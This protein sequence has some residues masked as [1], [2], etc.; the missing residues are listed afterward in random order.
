LANPTGVRGLTSATVANVTVPGNVPVAGVDYTIDLE[1]GGLHILP[2]STKIADDDD[3]TVTYS[4]AAT[5]YI[6]VKSGE[7]AVLEGQLFFLATN[8]KGT[9]FDYL[10]PYVQ[11]RPEGDFALK[12]DEWQQISFAFEALKRDD[13]TASVY[14]NGRAGLTL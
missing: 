10:F 8:P 4:S 3:I 12:G 7:S 14:S 5:S 11:L 1:T 9:K 13:N 2:G 6:Q